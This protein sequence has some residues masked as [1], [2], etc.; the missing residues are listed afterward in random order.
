M[1]MVNSMLSFSGLSEGFWGEAMLT[2]CYLL[3]RVPNKRNKTTSYELWY[4]KRLNLSFLRVWGCRAVVRLT[5]PKRKTL[6]EKGIDCIFVGYVEHSKAY[7]FC[8]IEP[9]D[10]VSINSIIESRDVMFVENINMIRPASDVR[11]KFTFLM[12]LLKN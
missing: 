6:G 1:E 7:R 9:N 12:V 10:S 11:L 5:D 3:N 8:D 4:K 2:A